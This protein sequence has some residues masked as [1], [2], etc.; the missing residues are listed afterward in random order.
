MDVRIGAV[1]TRRRQVLRLLGVL[2]ALMIAFGTSATAVADVADDTTSAA[3]ITPEA[4]TTN[5]PELAEDEEAEPSNG[6]DDSTRQ[7]SETATTTVPTPESTNQS[8]TEVQEDSSGIPPSTFLQSRTLLSTLS[9]SSPSYTLSV[10]PAS[11]LKGSGESFTVKVVDS[12][13][14]S[15]YFVYN[16]PSGWTATNS[17]G[18]AL[19]QVSTNPL[20]LRVA[21][22]TIT[23]AGIKATLPNTYSGT[24]NDIQIL[25]PDTATNLLPDSDGGSFDY[26]GAPGQTAS[27]NP[28]LSLNTTYTQHKATEAQTNGATNGLDNYV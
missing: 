27:A 10:S 1:R 17:D 28:T 19:T 21:G 13:P 25:K 2:S 15:A 3:S 8:I 23:N 20:I 14:A 4:S 6:A 18:S 5:T 24:L 11:L 26:D 22:A 12:S 7:T 16:V 9:Q